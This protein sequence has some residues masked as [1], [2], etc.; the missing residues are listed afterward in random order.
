[1]APNAADGNGDTGNDA[2]QGSVASHINTVVQAYNSLTV[3]D[4]ASCSQITYIR[5]LSELEVMEDPAMNFPL[6]LWDFHIECDTPGSTAFIEIYLD[7][8]YE[9]SGW[10]YYKHLEVTPGQWEYV[11]CF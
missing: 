3:D 5:H 4:Q 8:V 2:D 10:K 11:D 7:K 9:T 1:M 6:G